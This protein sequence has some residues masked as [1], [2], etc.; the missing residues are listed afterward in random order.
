[1]VGFD[2]DVKAWPAGGGADRGGRAKI[3]GSR[4]FSRGV[5]DKSGP[6]PLVRNVK[7]VKKLRIVVTHA[8]ADLLDL[9]LYVDLADAYVRK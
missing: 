6:I 7:D 9:G 2:D 5:K 4:R 3:G 1:M 8:P